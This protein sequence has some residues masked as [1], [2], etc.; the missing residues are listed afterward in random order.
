MPQVKETTWDLLVSGDKLH[1]ISVPRCKDNIEIKVPNDK[2]ES[3]YAKGWNHL[4]TNKK[5]TTIYKE[6]SVGAAFEDEVWSVFY[7]MGFKIMNEN[8]RFAI[9]YGEQ[10]KISKQI[11]IVAIDDETCLLIECKESWKYDTKRN[12]QMDINEVPAYFVK[13]CNVLKERYNNLKFKCIFATKNITVTQHD[14]D[15]MKEN[16]I[17][18]FDYSTVLYY[19]ALASHLG[20]AAKYQLLGQ[21][22]A[23]QNIHNIDA[24]IPAIR[25]KM[26][27]YTY[28]SFVI[29]PEKLL[30]I[31]YVLHK[32]NANNDYEDL[33]PSYQ[34]LIKKDRLKSVRAFINDGNF[35]PN[36]IIIS[37]DAK[38]PLQFDFASKEKNDDSLTKMGILHLPQK[39]QSAYIIDGQ[40]RLYGY[41]DS[42]Y[43][44]NNS[45]PVV[46]FENLDK[47]TQLKLFM[48]INLN[49]KAV[50]KALRNILEIDVYYDSDNPT[51]A[52]CALLGKIAKRLGEDSSSAL[53]GRVII[54]EDAGTARCCITIEN[55]KLALSKTK[56][57]NKLKKNGQ[58]LKAGILDKNNN[59]KTFNAVYRPFVKFINLIRDN[60]TTEWNSDDSFFVKNNIVGAYIRLF[61]DMVSIAYNKDHSIV[62]NCDAL[63]KSIC[64]H[65]D[66]LI[67]VLADLNANERESIIKQRGA[68]APYAVYRMLEMKMFEIDSS[69]SN[70][71]IEDYYTQNYRNY[72][73]DAKPKIAKIK[74]ILLNYLKTV[75]TENDWKRKYLSEKQENDLM[76]R[77][78]SRNIS[79]SRSGIDETVDEWDEINLNDMAEIINFSA[80]WT[81]FFKSKF[82]EWTPN[83]NKNAVLSIIKTISKCSDNI[84]NGHKIT[85]TDYQEIERLYKSM[86]GEE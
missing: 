3:Y 38:K 16:G 9:V 70:E 26:G 57:F 67:F 18:H 22:F 84:R 37:I 6:K 41:S 75:F 20:T 43:A 17:V 52:Q 32:T 29:S 53:S 68:G 4:K 56:F 79:N 65:I 46:A 14:K 28:Y 55:I 23:G 81:T 36:S 45:I 31:S 72:N 7:N 42:K 12:L 27:P 48:D 25:G 51:L 35:F 40:H 82:N 80:N 5:N 83:A 59:E 86:L 71:D 62:D 74:D 33:L 34:R 69:F 58:V 50:P 21:L 13:C 73:D 78:N 19:K 15:R 61:D 63:F 30:K 11:D 10:S 47:N 8:N 66:L 76:N 60:F 64:D 77:I 1:E 85:G 39:Y 54:G 44:A 49:Q 2:V 24:N